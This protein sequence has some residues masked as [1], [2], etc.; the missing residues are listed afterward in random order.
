MAAA[1][2]PLYLF[3]LQL[4]PDPLAGTTE[5]PEGGCRVSGHWRFALSVDI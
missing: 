5:R 4:K 2:P 3:R 1:A